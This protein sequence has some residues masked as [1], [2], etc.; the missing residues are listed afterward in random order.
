MKENMFYGASPIIFELAKKLRNN[1][2]NEEM[3]L[4]GILRDRFPT[5]KFRRQHPISNY[6]AD[7]YCHSEK[8]II[9]IDGSIHNLEDVKA[10]DEIR[11]KDL[12]NLG[13]KVIRFTNKDIKQNIDC[14]LQTIEKN[15]KQ[16]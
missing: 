4:W 7:L 10:N 2:T 9:E 6:I 8:L 16:F 15:I 12:E 5:L 11:Q 13:I 1:V 3:I 14:V